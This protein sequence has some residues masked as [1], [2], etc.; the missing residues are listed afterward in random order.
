MKKLLIGFVGPK[1]SGKTL[2]AGY[3]KKIGFV[4]INF[5]DNLDIELQER[6]EGLLLLLSKR[7][8]KTVY[9]LI[10]KKP[11]VPEIREL[12]PRA[13]DPPASSAISPAERSYRSS[14]GCS[15]GCSCG[16]SG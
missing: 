7:Y 8:K 6:F 10:Y 13:S 5:K 16:E 9:N 2:A 14:F 3:L 15:A 11:L 4:D 1:T 12:N